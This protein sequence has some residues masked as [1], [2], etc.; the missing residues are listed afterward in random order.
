MIKH[1]S[2]SSIQTYLLCPRA[3]RYRYVEKVQAPV[4]AVLPFGSA[5]HNAV[6]G[7]IREKATGSE[8]RPV[9]E[10]FRDAWARQLEREQ[11]NHRCGDGDPEGFGL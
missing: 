9:E 4:A 3:W 11:E 2:Y 1:L 10:M 7:Y 6:E 8:P 5:F